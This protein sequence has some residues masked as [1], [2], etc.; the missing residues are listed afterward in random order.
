MRWLKTVTPAA[1]SLFCLSALLYSKSQNP[2]EYA[3]APA[4]AASVYPETQ[5]GLKSLIGDML[6]AIQTGDKE[7]TTS[8]LSNLTIPDHG[9]WF[10]QTFGPE[11]GHLL[12][13]KYADLLAQMPDQ[14]IRRLKFALDGQ[15]TDV[16]II[17]MQKP[18]DPSLRL[19]RAIIEA[20]IQPSTLYRASL[21]KPTEKYGEDLGF[22]VFVDG[23]FRSV[24]TDVFQTFSA[25]LPLRIRQGGNVTA[26]RILRQV[27]PRYPD[28]ARK[29]RIQGD[30]VLHVIIDREGAV[31]EVEIVSGDPLLTQA[32]IEAVK[33]WKYTPTLLN[34][35][36]V[37][38]D[39]TITV[40]FVFNR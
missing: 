22:F 19:G 21:T 34:G 35:Q 37:E 2:Q 5:E 38:V 25:A 27:R 17:V 18:V 10:V 8:Y 36:P 40:S 29:A 33:Q 16:K 39:T 13:F 23:A 24:G 9:T 3:P 6:A 12:E 14:I 1:I 28:D 11:K 31:V 26:A 15:N 7:K 4:S 30:V 20:M 32:A